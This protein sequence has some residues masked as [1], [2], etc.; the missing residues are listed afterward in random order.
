[1][2]EAAHRETIR[3]PSSRPSIQP[4]ILARHRR[5][6][7]MMS[8]SR[9]SGLRSRGSIACVRNSRARGQQFRE[10]LSS[11]CPFVLAGE[12]RPGMIVPGLRCGM[13]TRLGATI[14][15]IEV[16]RGPIWRS[17]QFSS[18]ASKFVESL[19]ASLAIVAFCLNEPVSGRLRDK[20]VESDPA[21]QTIRAFCLN[22]QV[23]G[24]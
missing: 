23:S 18:I 7:P 19:S 13:L 10:R 4:S 14:V 17:S 22:E 2:R 5:S 11:L 20:F 6:S 15:V 9:V 24:R 1:M 8:C 16:F 21:S 3:R 12:V